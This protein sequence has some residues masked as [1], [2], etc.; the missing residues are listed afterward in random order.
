MKLAYGPLVD[1]VF[2][3][4]TLR[5]A[6]HLFLARFLKRSI[7]VQGG[8]VR[9]FEDGTV[10]HLVVARGFQAVDRSGSAPRSLVSV[11]LVVGG[12]NETHDRP[13]FW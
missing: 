2:T 1:F 12:K 11:S 9:L 10:P 13:T 5:A 8:T 7:V 3:A 6:G 4:G